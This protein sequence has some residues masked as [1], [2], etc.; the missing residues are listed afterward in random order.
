M[1]RDLDD[2]LRFHVEEETDAWLRAGVSPD[3]ARTAAYRSLGETLTRIK[4]DCR[5]TRRGRLSGMSRCDAARF[6]SRERLMESLLNDLKH[7]LRLF[8]RSPGFTLAALAAL[9]LGIGANVA[10][11]SVVNTVLL[12]PLPYPDADRLVVFATVF[13]A[14]PNYVTSDGKFNLFRQQDGVVQDVAGY[15]YT[16]ANLTGVEAPDQIQS[17][18]VTAGYFRLLGLPLA[19]GRTFTP[20]EVREHRPLAVLSD[21]FWKRAF[22][23]DP[24]MLGR[25][26]SLNGVAHEVIGIVAHGVETTAPQPIDV[27]TPLTIDPNSTNQIHYFSA[28]GRLKS[29]VTLEMANA[30]IRLAA[31]AFR[32]Q[33]P[34]ALAMGPQ[35]TFSLTPMREGLV[36]P[37]RSSLL[38]LV[39][40]VTCVLLIACANVAN[41]LLVRAAGRKREIA[42]RAAVGAARGRIVR[43]LLTESRSSR[44]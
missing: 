4:E 18:L 31:D 12:R 40:A 16:P 23:G 25:T 24:Q 8:S 34:N 6:T 22:A 21:A 27:W 37:V 39:G 10:I 36:G 20:E 35:A 42:V 29:G 3:E 7:A 33:Y 26:L 11:F 44:P 13:P 1:E 32:R 15:R 5:D 19:R 2:E 9:A 17:A 30:Q 38:V 28:L 43:Q 14:G 41:L